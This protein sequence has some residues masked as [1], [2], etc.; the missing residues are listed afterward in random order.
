MFIEKMS[1]SCKL[2]NELLSSELTANEKLDIMEK[3]YE[4]PTENKF[5]EEVNIMCNL[6]QGVEERGEKRGEKRGR[7]A[8]FA[9]GIAKTIFNMYDKNYSLEQIAEITDKTV[10]EVEEIIKGRNC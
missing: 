2:E 6:S 5:E 4:I 10:E 1:I 7:L 9:E 8:G 3:E